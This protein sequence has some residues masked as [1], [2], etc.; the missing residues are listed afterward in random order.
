MLI[1]MLRLAFIKE[2]HR[3]NFLSRQIHAIVTILGHI[4]TVA[5]Q[6]LQVLD[7]YVMLLCIFLMFQFVAKTRLRHQSIDPLPK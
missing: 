5:C 6:P 2:S 3:V 4:K 7:N 1:Y